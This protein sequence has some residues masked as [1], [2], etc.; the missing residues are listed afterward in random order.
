MKPLISYYGGKQKMV[1]HL[2]PLIPAHRIYIEPFA[3]GASLFFAKENP[4]SLTDSKYIEVLNDTNQDLINLYKVAKSRTE[5]FLREL[6]LI[7]YSEYLYRQAK[8]NKNDLCELKC[9]VNFFLRIMMSYSYQLDNGFA[10]SK[11]FSSSSR[12]YFS[13]NNYVVR[14]NKC[15]KR[16]SNV[17]IFDRDAINIIDNYDAQESFFYCDPP[18]PD[19]DQGHYSGYTQKDFKNLIEKLLNIKGSFML[20]CYENDAVPKDWEKFEFKTKNYSQNTN[21]GGSRPG[22]VECVW[23]KLS[24]YAKENQMSQMKMEFE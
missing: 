1:K 23:R 10:F 3:G 8:E 17:Y 22:R 6:D 2:L 7:P 21:N 15:V 5:E 24:D 20:S 14:L 4:S 16:L 13:Y 12:H 18:Y 11:N 19:T 9:A